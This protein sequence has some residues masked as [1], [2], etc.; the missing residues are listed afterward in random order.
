MG[1]DHLKAEE[2]AVRAT[3]RPENFLARPYKRAR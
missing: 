2:A 1:K 3:N